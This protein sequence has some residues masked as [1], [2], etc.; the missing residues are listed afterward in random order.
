MN[1]FVVG[2][3]PAS[4]PFHLAAQDHHHHHQEQ[5]ED[6]EAVLAQ[7]VGE[8]PVLE[9][10]VQG[11]AGVVPA[12]AS[13]EDQQDQDQDQ[14]AA[15]AAGSSGAPPLPLPVPVAPM[16]RASYSS[17]A[18]RTIEAVQVLCA[19]DRLK[20]VHK[21]RLITDIIEHCKGGTEPSLV[22]LAY[23]LLMEGEQEGRP[24]WDDEEAVEEFSAQCEII[25]EELLTSNSTQVE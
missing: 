17:P 14:A 3:D 15:P 6:Q 20:A 8:P 13:E 21:R 22:E 19:H 7:P 11:G 23:D 24:A 25:A 16:S 5:K 12:E 18:R 9:V 1:M 10:E 2:G 4:N